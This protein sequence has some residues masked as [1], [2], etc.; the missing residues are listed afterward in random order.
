MVQTSIHVALTRNT[1]IDPSDLLTIINRTIA[2]NIRKIGENKHMTITV[3]SVEKDGRFTFSGLH[4]VIMI[5]RTASKNVEL[6]ET[7]GMWG[8]WVGL[9]DDIRDMLYDDVFVMN[10]EDVFLLFT[11]GITEAWNSQDELFGDERLKDI[12]LELGGRSTKRI[13]QGILNALEDYD[14][15]DDIAMVIVKRLE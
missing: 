13:Q 9:I 5:Y 15:D 10:L 4:E 7:R 6:V 14:R 8:M 3:L 2:E 11:D 12:L 1:G